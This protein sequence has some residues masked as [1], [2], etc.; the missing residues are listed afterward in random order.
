MSSSQSQSDI[1]KN[2][3][4]SLNKFRTYKLSPTKIFTLIVSALILAGIVWFGWSAVRAFTQVSDSS[5]TQSPI[6]KFFGETLDPNALKGE[7]DGRINILFIGI[8]GSG[9]KG[10]ALADTIMVASLDPENKKLALLS[11]PRDLR[12][13]IAGNGNGKINSAHSYGESQEPGNGPKVLKETVGNVL[14]LPIHYFVRVDFTG[15]IKFIDA[16]GGIT[17]EIPKALDDPFYPDEKLEG[18]QPFSIGAGTQKLNGTI[19]LKYARSRQTTSD[20]DRASR[21]QQIL[22]AVRD[23]S[24]SLDILANPRKLS[25]IMGILGEHVRTDLSLTELERLYRILNTV[26]SGGI[27]TKVLDNGSDGPLMTVNEGGYYLVPKTGNFKE[28]QR[29]AHELF[30]DPNL[31]RENAKIE[32]LNASGKPGLAHELE[33]DLKSLG[34]NIVSIDKIVD[35]PATVLHDYSQGRAPFT[36]NF[37]SDRL[38]AKVETSAKPEGETAD[39]VLTLGADYEP[40]VLTP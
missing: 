15:F 24:L 29:I 32:I 35:A 20:F 25:E 3:G 16:L 19:A 27:V 8:G 38:N 2:H 7:G 1:D 28:V 33:L 12:V 31:K 6:L 9:H 17:V 26:D 34:Y 39:L 4:Q 30:T 40:V 11:L 22:L 14:D 13:P 36:V 23:R 18:Y 21:Q 37:L 10:G 5:D